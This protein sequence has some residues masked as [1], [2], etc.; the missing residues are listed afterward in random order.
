MATVR[1]FLSFE[2]NK[3]QKLRGDFYGQAN[4]GDSHHY[5]LDSSL[6]EDYPDDEWLDKARNLIRQCN[7]V[8]V[9]VGEDTHNAPGVKKEITVTHQEK[10]PIFQIRNQGK[11]WSPVPGAR[12]LIPWKWDKIDEKIDELLNLT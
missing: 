5:V 9:L 8:I 1:V 7:I 4:R 2:F 3:D 6:R 10:K 11:N 12:E